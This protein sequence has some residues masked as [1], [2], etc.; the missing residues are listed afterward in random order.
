MVCPPVISLVV[1]L[2]APLQVAL[3]GLVSAHA[4]VG[5]LHTSAALLE[6]SRPQE[7]LQYDLSVR[8]ARALLGVPASELSGSPSTSRICSV[9][10]PP[11][12][13]SSCTLLK[14]SGSASA[15]STRRCCAVC[16][17]EVPGKAQRYVQL[18]RALP[19][20][21][22]HPAAAD[23]ARPAGLTADTAVRLSDHDFL[24]S[25]LAQ[26]VIAEEG[27]VVIDYRRLQ[28]V[29]TAATAPRQADAAE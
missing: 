17:H 15:C 21:A 9:R 5:G 2:T 4:V 11:P 1:E 28:H 3:G 19:A 8:S 13:S 10:R 25:T 24:V 16:A 27:I 26:R 22:V 20:W 14:T 29:W 7:G 18:L 12:C 23:E 6:A